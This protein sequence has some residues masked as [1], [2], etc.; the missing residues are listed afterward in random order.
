VGDGDGDGVGDV[1]ST[2]VWLSKAGDGDERHVPSGAFKQ[3]T[4]Q[5]LV[6][7]QGC[8]SVVPLVT[9]HA[10]PPLAAAVVTM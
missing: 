5:G 3:S 4:A 1:G 9:G 6:L 7:L 8:T 10:A 2:I